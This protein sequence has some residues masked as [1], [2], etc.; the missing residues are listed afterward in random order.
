[1]KVNA[2]S[3]DFDNWKDGKERDKNGWR[4][5]AALAEQYPVDVRFIEMMPIGYGKQFQGIDHRTLLLQLKEMY[6][7]LETDHESMVLARL[8]IINPKGLKAAL[9]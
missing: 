4:A 2:V 7:D 6:P 1:M 3:I 5:M 9:A 8:F